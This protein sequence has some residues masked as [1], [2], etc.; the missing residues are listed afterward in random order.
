MGWSWSWSWSKEDEAVRKPP[1]QRPSAWLLSELNTI[2]GV[3]WVVDTLK[4]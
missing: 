4:A 1:D 2:P 3:A